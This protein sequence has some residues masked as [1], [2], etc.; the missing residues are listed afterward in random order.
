[1]WRLNLVLAGLLL[2]LHP[3]A[4]GTAQ[5]QRPD[6]STISSAVDSLAAIAVRDGVTPA[7][8]VAIAMDG[9]VVLARSYGMADASLGVRADDHTLWYIASTSKSFTGFGISLLADRGVVRFDTPITSLLPKARWHSGAH[10]EQLTLAHF[11]SH[12]HYLNDNAVVSSAA[13][14]GAIPEAR[15][16]ELLVL[17][18]PT[19][20]KDLVYS[21][22]GYNVAAMVIDTRQPDGWRRYLEQAVY[23]PAGLH[24]TYARVSGLDPR[25]I[26]RPHRLRSDGS[27]VTEPFQK[28]DATMNSAGGHLSTLNDLARW[29][30]VQM[31]SGRI[32]GRQVYPKSAVALSHKL[33]ARQTLA[34]AKHF[35]MFDRDGW[36]AGWDIGSYEGQRMVS[37]FGS[38]HTTRSHLSFLPGRRIG[39]VAMSTGG[40]GSS[41][42]DVIAAFAYDLE[43]GRP[44][45]RSRAAERLS[46]LRARLDSARRAAAIT[47]S[48]RAQ[49]QRQSLRRPLSDFV[50][51]FSEP[52]YGEV[53]FT[54]RDGRLEYGWGVLRGPVEIFDASR[55][56]LRIEIAGSGNTVAFSFAGQ[57]PARSIELQGVTFNRIP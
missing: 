31:D 16:P 55:D 25:R 21:N 20:T 14:S 24:E 10:A 6:A 5:Q 33:I 44:D 13:F 2:V 11:L 27:F 52:S 23:A 39:V 47:D 17:A 3:V 8:G 29:T 26:A 4:G 43:A 30:I 42:T 45:A 38:Y 34:Q 15:W 35:A 57:G 36:G 9:R 7:L 46:T 53:T 51:R 56:Q 32:D 19:G 28:V 54:L 1:M 41:L 49:R 18:T 37:R 40:F 12:T 22:F 50:G 48:T